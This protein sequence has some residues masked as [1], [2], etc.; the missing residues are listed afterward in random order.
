MQMKRRAPESG[1]G[2]C[3]LPGSQGTAA[4]CLGVLASAALLGLGLPAQPPALANPAES[5]SLLSGSPRVLKEGF[6]WSEGPAWIS[7]K[8]HW[9]FSD[10]MG[11]KQ[12]T[13]TPEGTLQEFRT[14]S[15]YANGNAV[16]SGG[17]I[18][19]AQH[20]RKLTALTPTGKV[21]SVLAAT[22][23]GKKLNSPNDV[24]IAA[25]GGIWFTD[26]P[27]GIIGYGP[28]KEPQELPFQ[29]VFRLKGGS[30]ELMD[31]S[32]GLPNGLGFSPDGKYL[33]VS[34]TKD[35]TIVRFAVNPS[36][37]KL[38]DKKLFARLEPVPGGG[39]D[40]AA[41]G[42]RVDRTGNVWASGPGG[43]TVLSPE[44]T[45]RCRIPFQAHVSNLAFGGKNTTFILVTSADKVF[46]LEGP[47]RF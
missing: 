41:D 18:V 12:Y 13:I 39:K 11:D 45:T 29:G 2:V 14:P 5:C 3:G 36:S 16:M 31:S 7:A 47:K 43:I 26:P 20:D 8:G 42:L 27:M 1:R 21:S 44:G 4:G 25:G 30:L 10:V 37:G 34:D 40:G 6:K 9:V 33:Y 23:Q 15:G 22:Y 17:M 32:M 35:N 38:S 28:K 24:A 46:L 19:S